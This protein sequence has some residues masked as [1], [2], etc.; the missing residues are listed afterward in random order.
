MA[1]GALSFSVM[2][3]GAK[4]VGVR[5]PL[6]EIVAARSL[7][8]AMI[9]GA[10]LY[11]RGDSFR[12]IDAHLLLRRAVIGF[13]ALSCYFYSVIHLPLA[14]AT[15]IYFV[16]PVLTALAAAVVLR[17]R[18]GWKEV[19]LVGLSLI[20]VVFV[21]RPGFLFGAERALD[22]VAVALGILSAFFAAA[23]YVTIRQIQ[24][25][26]P[27][28]V[29]FYFSAVTVL[30]SAPFL[31]LGFT[32]PTLREVG[33]II[34]MGVATHVGQ[35]WITWGFRMERAGRASAVGYLQILF[36]AGWGW[37]LFSEVPD[38][39]TWLG[40]GIIAVATLHLMRLH[41]AR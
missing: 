29:V 21:A 14:D 31:L 35:L 32:T 12:G 7:V 40:G 18:M 30:L 1:G 23:A 22:P 9:A 28:L 19:A 2:S 16:N 37:V 13:C 15:V 33:I 34:V 4:L 11:R 5:L 39:W 25:D 41:P 20:G 24:R 6:F 38:G 36:A 8:V 3:A 17:E 10:A 26:P 27:L